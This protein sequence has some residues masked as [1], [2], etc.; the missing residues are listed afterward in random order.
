MVWWDG[1]TSIPYR[2]QTKLEIA[3]GLDPNITVTKNK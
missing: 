1:H 2:H 3:W